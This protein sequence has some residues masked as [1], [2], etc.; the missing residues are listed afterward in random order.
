MPTLTETFETMLAETPASDRR[1]WLTRLVALQ[2][3]VDDWVDREIGRL[4]ATGMDQ[5]EARFAAINTPLDARLVAEWHMLYLTLFP[6]S[7]TIY[8]EAGMVSRE[9]ERPN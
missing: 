1:D 8:E 2:R 3:T 9:P 6:Q 7:R 4:L 5:D